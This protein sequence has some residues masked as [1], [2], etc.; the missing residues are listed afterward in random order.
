[1]RLF[2]WTA[3]W[4]E[5]SVDLFAVTD[6]SLTSVDNNVPGLIPFMPHGPSA[7][8]SG[9]GLFQWVNLGWP[10]DLHLIR[11]DGTTALGTIAQEEDAWMELDDGEVDQWRARVPATPR[12]AVSKHADD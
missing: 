3:S 1:L 12:E 2:N 6:C 4:R 9:S 10:E 7:L 5:R 8:E 11:S